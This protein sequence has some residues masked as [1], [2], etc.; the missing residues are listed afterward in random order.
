MLKIL[1]GALII[2]TCGI[3]GLEKSRSFSARIEQLRLLNAGLKMLE[4]EIVYGSTLLPLA[5]ARIGERFEGPVAS[6]FQTV[7]QR[8]QEDVASGALGAW[9][10]GLQ[11]LERKSS[12]QTQDIEILRALGPMLGNSGVGDQVKNL[13]LTRQHL[14]QQYL[15][16]L[17]EN[18]RKGK[19]WRTMGFLVGITLVLLLY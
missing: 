18:N 19:M 17:E 9:Q 14:G 1:G 3:I 6:F 12:L 5:F 4:T 15:A 10:E 11:E 13:E 7:A 8:L 16:A 2:M